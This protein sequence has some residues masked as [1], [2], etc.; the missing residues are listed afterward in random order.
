MADVLQRVITAN[1]FKEGSVI[2]SVDKQGNT[3]NHRI[4]PKINYTKE[5]LHQSGVLSNRFDDTGIYGG[6]D[7]TSP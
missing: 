7:A 6:G 4:D 1:N 5:I 3:T 2:V